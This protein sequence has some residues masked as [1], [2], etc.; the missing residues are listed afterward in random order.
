MTTPAPRSLASGFNQLFPSRARSGGRV[1]TGIAELDEMLHGGF[2]EG[3]AVLIAGS[4]GSGKTTL[5]LQYLVNGIVKD[6]DPG[7]YITFEQMPDQIYR[8]A[9]S[10]GWDLHKL[11]DQNKFR[12]I[13]TS[14]DILLESSGENLL[15]D[16]LKEIEPKRVAID[17][18]SHLAMFIDKKDLRKEAYRLISF[19]KTKGLSSVLIWESAQNSPNQFNVTDMNLSFLVDC[20]IALKPVEIESSIRKAMVILKMRGSD[21]DKHLREFEITGNGVKITSA[22]SNYEGL[23]TGTPRKVASERF[24]E[25]MRGSSDKHK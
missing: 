23:I 3:D 6:G 14:P 9:K 19:L 25:L 5:A 10:F 8:D 2:M 15:D 21:H 16:V 24:L 12:L 20:V 11:E 22:F 17:S 4:A 1:K 7:V 18:L 13:C